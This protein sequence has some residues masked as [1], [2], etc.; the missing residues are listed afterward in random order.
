MLG[1][2]AILLAGALVISSCEGPAGPAGAD[3][4]DGIRW[5]RWNKMD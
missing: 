3:G 1:G 4:K 2:L 5:N